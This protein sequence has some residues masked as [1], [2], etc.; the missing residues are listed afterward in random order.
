MTTITPLANVLY[1]LS[2]E[3]IF[4]DHGLNVV[5]SS[6]INGPPMDVPP[7][8]P[9][10][11]SELER[12]YQTESTNLASVLNSITLKTTCDTTRLVAK[13]GELN[14]IWPDTMPNLDEVIN[15]LS[16][17][18]IYDKMIRLYLILLVD[19]RYSNLKT[20]RQ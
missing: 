20:I 19:F 13:L 3:S 9:I 14:N 2:I 8:I 12:I 10:I 16:H 4:V 15:D 17:G 1:N 11:L 18:S 5:I 6:L 7:D